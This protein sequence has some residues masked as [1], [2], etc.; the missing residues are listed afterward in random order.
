LHQYRLHPD[1]SARSLEAKG[2]RFIFGNH[3]EELTEV[4]QEDVIVTLTDGEKITAQVVLLATGRTPNVEGFGLENTTVEL[5]DKNAIQVND[6]LQTT[7]RNV[8]HCAMSKA[9]CNSL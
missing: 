1:E 3:A 9:A 7:A 6:H 8:G 5:T 4:D 2:I